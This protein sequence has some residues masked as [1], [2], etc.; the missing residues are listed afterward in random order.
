ME[1]KIFYDGDYTYRSINITITLIITVNFEIVQLQ[2]SSNFSEIVF[3]PILKIK[4]SSN[5]FKIER[6][7]FL[8]KHE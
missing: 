5:F 3:F 4:N 8:K 2:N 7:Q 6:F 1:K